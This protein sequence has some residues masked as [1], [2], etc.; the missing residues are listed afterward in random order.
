MKKPKLIKRYPNRKLYNTDA[1]CYVT[2]SDIS[3]MIEQGEEV[4]IVNNHDQKD[5][6]ASTLT[7]I[8][9]EKQKLSE[10]LI[11]VATLRYIIQKSVEIVKC[12]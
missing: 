8:I 1:S 5:I 3:K 10:N 12:A 7:Q 11:S 9:F 2:L 4:I 6:T